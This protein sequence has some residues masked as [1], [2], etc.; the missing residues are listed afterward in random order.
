MNDLFAS[1]FLAK[2]EKQAH[3]NFLSVVRSS[4]SSPTVPLSIIAEKE[5]KRGKV[6]AKGRCLS[7]LLRGTL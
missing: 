7:Q 2:G 1:S 5:N 3:D 4:F 6:Y